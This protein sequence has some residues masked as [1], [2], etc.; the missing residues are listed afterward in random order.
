MTIATAPINEVL[1]QCEKRHVTK[2]NW[3][4]QVVDF[5]RTV[6]C[7]T[8][9][10]D[11]QFVGS[12]I[13]PTDEVVPDPKRLRKG[14]LEDEFEETKPEPEEDNRPLNPD[15][16]GGFTAGHL[17]ALHERRTEEELEALLAERLAVLRSRR[18]M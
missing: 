13:E 7:S 10:K 16:P 8:C 12:T 1:Y 6:N 15:S 5:P 11:A 2:R 9:H 18:N 3:H 14:F 4:A 17:R